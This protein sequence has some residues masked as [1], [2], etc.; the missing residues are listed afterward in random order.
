MVKTSN[1]QPFNEFR[2]C[3]Q[4]LMYERLVTP[5]FTY[6]CYILGSVTNLVIPL[7]IPHS[8]KGVLNFI[9]FKGVRQVIL[10]G[11]SSGGHTDGI[12]GV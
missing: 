9:N 2:Y 11:N 5:G 1:G 3:K 6:C 7:V 10:L 4:V 12:A 8:M